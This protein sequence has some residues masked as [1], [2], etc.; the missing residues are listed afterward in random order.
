MYEQTPTHCRASGLVSHGYLL[1]LRL[2]VVAGGDGLLLDLLGLQEEE[3]EEEEEDE[4]QSAQEQDSIHPHDHRPVSHVRNSASYSL[5]HGIDFGVFP[6]SSHHI[7]SVLLAAAV[8]DKHTH[9]HTLMPVGQPHWTVMIT[10][11]VMHSGA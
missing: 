2:L 10:V 8:W 4:H 3:E 7:V 11:G 9:R 5:D 1:L 6:F